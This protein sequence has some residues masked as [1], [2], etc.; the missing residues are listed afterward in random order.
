MILRH[1]EDQQVSDAREICAIVIENL[2]HA[3]NVPHDR[4]VSYMADMEEQG[5]IEKD[6]DGNTPY[7]ITP[8]GVRYLDEFRKVDR[9]GRIFGV[10][11]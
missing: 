8:K 7:A 6:G 11:T 4:L 3:V 1:S 9:L 5:L 10:E 2:L